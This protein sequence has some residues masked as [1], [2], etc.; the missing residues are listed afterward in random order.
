MYIWVYRDIIEYCTSE[1][2]QKQREVEESHLVLQHG[3]V[4]I[5]LTIRAQLMSQIQLHTMIQ[6]THWSNQD[7]NGANNILQAQQTHRS[8]HLT[9]LSKLP[10]MTNVQNVGATNWSGRI[11]CAVAY[12]FPHP[13]HWVVCWYFGE[14]WLFCFASTHRAFQWLFPGLHMHPV[15]HKMARPRSESGPHLRTPDRV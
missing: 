11:K 2:I 9:H 6:Q 14:R 15:T 12:G 8:N 10:H 1:W 5:L 4:L 13:H 7:A 3:I